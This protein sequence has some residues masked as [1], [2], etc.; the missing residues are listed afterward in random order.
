MESS[1]KLEFVEFLDS[2]DVTFLQPS[3]SSAS[4]PGCNFSLYDDDRDLVMF[5]H[6]LSSEL[7]TEVAG[8]I[9]ELE[10]ITQ[11]SPMDDGG[12]FSTFP[13]NPRRGVLI[14]VVRRTIDHL[15]ARGFTEVSRRTGWAEFNPKPY[16]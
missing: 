4:V 15:L 5:F 12:H 1:T 3:G 10:P 8:A 16:G 11:P 13:G 6:G 9:A 7:L 14:E 2:Y